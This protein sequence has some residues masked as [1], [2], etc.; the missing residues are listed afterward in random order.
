[1]DECQVS[2]KL[3]EDTDD[4]GAICEWCACDRRNENR[5]TVKRAKCL[6][7]KIEDLANAL[8]VSV[9]LKQISRIVM[10]A[11]KVD[12]NECGYTDEDLIHEIAMYR[13]VSL[14]P[15]EWETVLHNLGDNNEIHDKIKEQLCSS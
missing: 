13:G 14:L 2:L 3:R 7:E 6:F 4:Q 1:M 9:D 8:G 12:Q 5:E 11:E 10:I 15:T